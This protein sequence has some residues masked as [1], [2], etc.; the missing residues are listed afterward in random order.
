MDDIEMVKSESAGLGLQLNIEKY[1]VI[2]DATW[3]Q[4]TL[5]VKFGGLGIQRAVQPATW[6][7]LLTLLRTSSTIFS[8]FISSKYHFAIR[9][10]L[11]PSGLKALTNLY[12]Y[13][14]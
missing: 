7:L 4:P 9:G 5:P 1:A 11:S 14:C 8:H 2:C 13:D 12:L 6:P 10:M 3:I